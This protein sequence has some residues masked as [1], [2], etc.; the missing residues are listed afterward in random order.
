MRKSLKLPMGHQVS[1]SVSSACLSPLKQILA[2]NFS[3]VPS[4]LIL[5]LNFAV[6][7]IIGSSSPGV[8]FLKHFMVLIKRT[9]SDFSDFNQIAHPQAQGYNA[10]DY[11]G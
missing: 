8:S 4:D 10:V 11:Y 6:T 2:F 9:A 1:K 3:I 5:V 7:G